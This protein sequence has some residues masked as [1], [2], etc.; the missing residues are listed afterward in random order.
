M[1]RLRRAEGLGFPDLEARIQELEP[2]CQEA[3]Q[4]H[5]AS[6]KALEKPLIALQELEALGVDLAVFTGRPP[7]EWALAVE[8]LGFT[9][10]AVTDAAPHLRK[11][12]P[13]GLLQLADAFRA[14]EVLFVGDTRDDAAALQGARAL[15][16][17][18]QWTFAAV[19]PDRERIGG[20]LLG[21]TLRSLLPELQ[22]RLS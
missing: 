14:Q 5:Y 18:L 15:R 17:D 2:R 12:R 7:E 10:P 20:E 16:P 8:V 3:V 1:D 21:E 19:G 11:P 9:L 13:D 6:T 22:R 4:R